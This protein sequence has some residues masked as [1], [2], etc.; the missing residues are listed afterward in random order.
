MDKLQD[1]LVLIL[2]FIYKL[3]Y[4]E[5]ANITTITNT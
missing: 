5:K 1:R 4:S 3:Y 2:E